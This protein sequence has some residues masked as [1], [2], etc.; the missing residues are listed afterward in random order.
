MAFALAEICDEVG[1]PAGVLN[2]VTGYGHDRRR[3]AHRPSRRRPRDVH[4]FRGRRPPDRR[5]HRAQPGARRARARRQVGLH[6]ARRRRP[7][8]GRHV[9][10]DALHAQQRP[11]LHRAHPAAGPAR[12]A[13]RSRGDRR[14]GGAG[15]RRSA[16]RSTRPRRWARSSRPPS[17]AGSASTSATAC[18]RARASSPA[19]R[20]PPLE[21]WVLRR[22][23]GLLRRAAATWRSP[24]RRSSG[25]CSRSSPTTT[26]RTRS[27]SPT[28]RATDSPAPSGPATRTR[29]LRVAR[30]IRTGQ[31]D[32]N[33]G[34]FNPCAPFGGVGGSGQGRELG[35]HGLNEFFYVKS[36]QR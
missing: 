4:R 18:R 30:R 21:R 23:D 29:A 31:V 14:R 24:R 17:A 36:I 35:A 34:A 19:A 2:L 26:R 27:G 33:G 12:A 10:R 16:T 25:R 32:V 11:D 7:R 28:T 20:E 9:V 6:R 1:L 13:R 22:P 8:A 15:P 3:G 5:G